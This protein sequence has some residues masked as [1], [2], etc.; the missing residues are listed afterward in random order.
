MDTSYA[1]HLH[2]LYHKPTVADKV[3]GRPGIIELDVIH[4]QVNLYLLA[5]LEGRQTCIQACEI[6]LT[7]RKDG[8]YTHLYTGSSSI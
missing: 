3:N 5:R 8:S 2:N 6:S 1:I 7:R 4:A